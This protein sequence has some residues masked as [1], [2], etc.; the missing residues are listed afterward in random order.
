MMHLSRQRPGW[1]ADPAG[2]L[3]ASIVLVTQVV[4]LLAAIALALHF[5]A[6]LVPISAGWGLSNYFAYQQDLVAVP[7]VLGTLAAVLAWR[8]LVTPPRALPDMRFLIF[9]LAAAVL[10]LCYAGTYFVFH[11]YGLSLDEFMSGFDARILGGG[12][13]FAPLPVE[14]RNY[15]D[16]LQPL[17]V[18][19]APGSIAW[20]S[21]YLP[22]NAAIRAAFEWLGDGA[23]APPVLAAASVVLLYLVARKLAPEDNEFAAV[24]V[25]LFVTSSQFLLTAMTPYAMT[26]HLAFNLAWLWLAL[27]DRRWSRIA[28]VAVSFVACGLHQ[29]VFHPLFVAPFLL[30]FWWTGRRALAL[31][32][33]AAVSAC[34]LAWIAYWQLA[35]ALTLPD[36]PTASHGGA[37]FAERVIRVV[38]DALQFE[39]IGLMLQNLLRFVTWQ[40][41]L[42][43]TLF[44]AAWLTIRRQ[45]PIAKTLL[46][47]ILLMFAAT[48]VLMPYQG[49]G[50]GY[51]YFHGLLGSFALLG[52]YGW[53]TI[54]DQA[55]ELRRR[56]HVGLG[57]AI[58]VS[59]ALLLPLRAYQANR[60]ATPYAVASERIAKT[61]AEVVILDNGDRWYAWD[62]VRNDPFLRQ[63]PIILHARSLRPDDLTALCRNYRVK[64]ISSSSPELALIRKMKSAP[65]APT[66]AQRLQRF[67]VAGCGKNPVQDK[68]ISAHGA[69]G[70]GE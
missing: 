31:L 2:I 37:L 52:A 11:D 36:A 58:L 43:I 10:I 45:P 49:H 32:Y 59:L 16:A 41:P 64:V 6:V 70:A 24:A 39:A 17:F 56:L 51:R 27:H 5:F 15:A 28:A 60:F 63:R 8:P 25:L 1:A 33:F 40:N 7:I 67:R 68:N 30:W 38:N 53:R 23:L 4:I 66:E 22:G 54:R 55:P 57:V 12:V 26:A 20:S 62:L 35:I 42:T 29:M 69:A 21:A 44:A 14:W 65:N 18:M 50:W 48:V 13:L 46:G 3:T 34:A 19:K 47:G 61:D 9:A